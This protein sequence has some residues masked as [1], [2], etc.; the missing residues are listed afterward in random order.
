MRDTSVHR[1]AS[2]LKAKVIYILTT[3]GKAGS[4]RFGLIGISIH[5]AV[6]PKCAQP[7][8]LS[9]CLQLSLPKGGI[10]HGSR[11]FPPT[12]SNLIANRLAPHSFTAHPQSHPLGKRFYTFRGTVE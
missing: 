7:L 1:T 9:L 5:L 11:V 3:K 6:H 12:A 4:L 8:R 10:S 2:T